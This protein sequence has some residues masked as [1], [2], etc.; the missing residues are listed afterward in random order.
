MKTI[1]FLVSGKGGSLKYIHQALLLLQLS[2]KL[3]ISAVIADRECDAL[4]YSKANNLP[5]YTIK[6]NR[7]ENTTLFPILD[8]Y[9]PDFIITNIHKII[10]PTTLQ[11]STAEFINLHYSLLP[12]FKGLI[13]METVE[14][15]KQ[16]NV[17]F[18]GATCHEVVEEVDAGNIISQSIFQANWNIHTEKIIQQVFRDA[19][20]ILLNSILIKAKLQSTDF[21]TSYQ[22]SIFSPPLFFNVNTFNDDFWEYL[23]RL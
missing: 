1:L 15:A 8:K 21:V 18:I 3:E 16:Q 20:F 4:R 2:E 5:S 9:K 10:D 7:K 6:Y 11:N 12:A 13:G 17:Q 22:N 19:C 14:K 23:N